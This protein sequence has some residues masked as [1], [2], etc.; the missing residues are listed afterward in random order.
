LIHTEKALTVIA[1]AL[2]PYVGRTMAEASPRAHCERLGIGGDGALSSAD[3]EKLLQRL[4]SALSV[5]VGGST[6]ESV[7]ATI[8]AGLDNGGRE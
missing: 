3:L 5:F 7:M 1:A 4:A 2:A 8:R 6:T